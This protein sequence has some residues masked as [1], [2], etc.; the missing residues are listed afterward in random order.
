MGPDSSF[1]DVGQMA[2]GF[3]LDPA[4]I[5]ADRASGR[6]TR[7]RIAADACAT[8]LEFEKQLDLKIE[9]LYHF[10]SLQLAE[11]SA[12]PEYLARIGQ[13]QNLLTKIGETARFS[14]RRS[15]RS[16]MKSSR[17]SSN[18]PAL[19]EW[20]IT[21]HKIRRM[22][23]HVLSEPEERLLALGSVGAGRIRRRV[24]AADRCRH[25]VRR[26][27]RTRQGRE[28]PLTQSSFSSFLVK[29]DHAIAKTRV[30]SVLRGVSRTTNT[31]SPPSLAYSVKADVFRA[32]ARNYPS[33]S[34]RR[35]FATTCRSRFTTGL[36]AAVR[37]QSRT[38]LSLLRT[39][40]ARAR[41]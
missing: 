8:C 25:E 31:R 19:A 37:E 1:R 41:A 24:L 6:E 7:R 5:S 23:P 38:A 28:R 10:A 15:R 12:N 30:S 34:R 32:R 35:S 22:K 2:G 17:N 21:L 33:R 40:P 39:A 3:R 13:L 18:D 11:D 26:A 27:S 14:F 29:R 20:Q 9:R 4:D 36:I 16:T